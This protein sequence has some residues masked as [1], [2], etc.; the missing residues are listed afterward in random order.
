[1]EE[2]ARLHTLAKRAVEDSQ[3]E[4]LASKRKAAA[5]RE[6]S[7]TPGKEKRSPEPLLPKEGFAVN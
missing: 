6:G 7:K 4:H 1:M 2:R 5:L 3:T